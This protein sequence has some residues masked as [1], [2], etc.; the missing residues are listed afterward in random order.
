MTTRPTPSVPADV[1]AAVST[2]V[3]ESPGATTTD[4]ADAVF[5]QIGEALF[6]AHEA[7][8]FE[9]IGAQR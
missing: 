5:W 6:F 8:I 4:I 2:A 7:T 9:L 3:A 1:A